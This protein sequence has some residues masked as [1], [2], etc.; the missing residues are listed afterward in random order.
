MSQND[1][2]RPRGVKTNNLDHRE[3]VN[4]QFHNPPFWMDYGGG[5]SA[6]KFKFDRNEMTLER[7]G[8]QAI[9]GRP[10]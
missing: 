7:G 4:G 8:P 6:R 1:F 5:S 2:M 9:R 3:M 10:L